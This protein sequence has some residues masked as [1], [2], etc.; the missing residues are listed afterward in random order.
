L[1]QHNY[2]KV[3]STRFTNTHPETGDH[4]IPY[5]RLFSFQEWLDTGE[6]NGTVLI[7]DPDCVFR[8]KVSSRVIP[9]A[10]IAQHWRGFAVVGKWQET[11]EK[12][13]DVDIALIQGITWPALL[14]TDDMR[15]MMPRWI[16]LTSLI[17]QEMD[18]WE[19]DMM[20][21]VVTA[22]EMGIRFSDQ[23]LAAVL[24][25]P[26]EEGE[27]APV[28]HYCQAVEAK[29]GSQLWFKQGYQPWLD[30]HADPSLAKLAYCGD[31]V[32][33]L[34]Q[35]VAIQHPGSAAVEDI[36]RNSERVGSVHPAVNDVETNILVKAYLCHDRVLEFNCKRGD[37]TMLMLFQSLAE[38]TAVDSVPNDRLI[39]VS[40]NGDDRQVTHFRLSHLIGL[41]TIPN[42]AA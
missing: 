23:H 11:V 4:Y 38:N 5:N 15:R 28:I 6:Q 14:H 34:N 18:A 24:N 39:T 37:E 9:G 1:P 16:E 13:S 12:L 29:D 35:Y 10:P 36:S 42:N 26:E 33:I 27:E 3:I 2:T 8:K 20:A 19:S 7:L 41:E 22:A 31:L 25:W 40:T 21:F 17:R 32:A 30:T